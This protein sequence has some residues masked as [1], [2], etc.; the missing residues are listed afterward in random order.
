M[1]F[2]AFLKVDKIPGESTDAKHKG[3][4]EIE[5]W[6]FG[7]NQ[8]VDMGSGNAPTGQRAHFSELSVTKPFDKASNL[9][10]K[11]CAE[12]TP[13]AE[14]KLELC[15][16]TGKKET[17]LKIILN[18]VIVSSFNPGGSQGSMANESVGFAYGSIKSTYTL[19][20]HKAGKKEGNVECGWS[21]IE[22]KSI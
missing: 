12:A 5:S 22:N 6:S 1:A 10:M 20:G 11:A 4:I 3:E 19:M 9:L 14:V 15:R 18:D 8:M 16:P 21:L 2:D 7:V 17:Y 13:I